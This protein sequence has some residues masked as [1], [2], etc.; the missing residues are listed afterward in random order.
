MMLW[1]TLFRSVDFSSTKVPRFYR[2]KECKRSGCKLWRTPH[3]TNGLLCGACSLKEQKYP[4]PIDADGYVLWEGRKTDQIQSRLPAVPTED[5]DTY[6]GY[7]SVPDAGVA[8]WR[9]LPT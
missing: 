3:D 9:R 8:W 2:C 7:T 4:G 6:Y 5:G 1:D